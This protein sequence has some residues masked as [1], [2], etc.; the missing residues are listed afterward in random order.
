[1]QTTGLM[2]TLV[3]LPP[4][5]IGCAQ[6]GQESWHYKLAA[7]VDAVAEVSRKS[8]APLTAEQLSAILGAPDLAQP[9]RQFAFMLPEN[10]PGSPGYRSGV[11]NKLW[12]SYRL[13]AG[14][15]REAS[16]WQAPGALDK[17]EVWLYDERKHFAKPLPHG[18]GFQAY[19]FIVRDSKVMDA[20]IIM[21][22]I[23]VS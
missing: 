9:A 1:M 14:R 18:L 10:P 13:K 20:G 16:G 2:L 11:M 7:L 17:C 23:A 12:R 8:I 5:M 15:D 3:V 6:P 22:W 21:P 19:Y 4:L